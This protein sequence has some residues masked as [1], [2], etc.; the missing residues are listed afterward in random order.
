MIRPKPW[1]RCRA[2]PSTIWAWRQTLSPRTTRIWTRPLK[3]RPHS[4]GWTPMR[5]SMASSCAT[6]KTNRRSP[7][8]SMSR[9]TTA[10]SARRMQRPSRPAANA[11][12]STWQRRPEPLAP[13]GMASFAYRRPPRGTRSPRAGRLFLPFF[14][15]AAPEN[16]QFCTN[17]RTDF[18]EQ[19]GQ[20]I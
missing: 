9:G 6:P 5:R 13:A 11:W 18:T 3:K 1:W 16:G 17:D 8:S 12:R 20:G 2:S 19:R 15:A 10:T 7:G 4:P 14:G